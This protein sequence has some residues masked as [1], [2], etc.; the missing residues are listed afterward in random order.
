MWKSI[1]DIADL[2][3]YPTVDMDRFHEVVFFDE[4]FGDVAQ[5]DVDILGAVQRCL[6]VEILNVKS[7]KLGAFTGKD[8]VEE[9]LDEV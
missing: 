4:L 6:E 3:V 2:K 5:F 7:D 1:N 8:A 9:E